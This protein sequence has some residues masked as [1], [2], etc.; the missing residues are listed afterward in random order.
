M[1]AIKSGGGGG[2]V[3]GSGALFVK[4]RE[5]QGP[6]GGRRMRESR[7][8]ATA[9]TSALVAAAAAAAVVFPALSERKEIFSLFRPLLG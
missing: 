9:A 3:V 4:D 1:L 8:R 7:A 5:L 2:G 6:T